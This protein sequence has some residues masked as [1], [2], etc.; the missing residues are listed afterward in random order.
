MEF[1]HRFFSDIEVAVDKGITRFFLYGENIDRDLFYNEILGVADLKDSLAFNLVLKKNIDNVFSFN[2]AGV[3]LNSKDF[4]SKKYVKQEALT[5]TEIDSRFLNANAEDK[6][7]DPF[8]NIR[9]TDK[10]NQKT[11]EVALEATKGVRQPDNILSNYLV[12]FTN[13][14]KSRKEPIAIII[15]DLDW[16]VELFKG[17]EHK[18][19]ILEEIDKWKNI[20]QVPHLTF[21][22]IRS[23]D[24]LKTY[25]NIDEKH[26]GI[27]YIGSPTVK[28]IEL[29]YSRNNLLFSE[30]TKRLKE[31]TLKVLAAHSKN[32]KNLLLHSIHL[33]ATVKHSLGD[34]FYD[35]KI[36]IKEFKERLNS[37]LEEVKWD[38]VFLNHEEKIEIERIF[39]TFREGNVE[40]KKT[41]PK[42]IILYGPPGTGK[43]HIARALSNMGGYF[44][45]PLKLADIKGEFVGQSGKN[46]QRIFREARISAPTLLFIDEVDTIFGR[47]GSGDQ[48]SYSIDII[49]Q[50]L[51]ETDGVDTAGQ[52]IFIVCTTNRLEMVDP[53]II[54][55]FKP[56]KVDLPDENNRKNLTLYFLKNGIDPEQN[57]N[58]LKE[59]IQ[60]SK[61]LSGRD[62]KTLSGHI[63]KELVSGINLLEAIRKTF[64]KLKENIVSIESSEVFAPKLYT[65]N[66]TYPLFTHIIGYN[67]VKQ[68]IKDL[69]QLMKEP[70]KFERFGIEKINGILLYGPPGN[71]KTQFAEAC[72]NEFGMDYV[73]I[74]SSNL[75]NSLVSGMIKQIEEA[76]EK[77]IILSNFNPVLLFFDEFDAI[78]SIEALDIRFR[79]ALLDSINRIRKMNH[80]I[81]MAATNFHDRLD[82]AVIRKG[83]FDKHIEFPNPKEENIIPLIQYFISDERY[84]SDTL[85]YEIIKKRIYKFKEKPSTSDVKTFC[86]E[87]KMDAVIKGRFNSDGKVILRTE[88]FK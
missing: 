57:K 41:L 16:I 63:K 3:V 24:E 74:V 72:A 1:K 6:E 76:V 67:E 37:T 59:I 17:R 9:E 20:S 36:V 42:G 85:D 19:K 83:R 2:R 25:Y 78:A 71:G 56:V 7:N 75:A 55:R 27:I 22:I 13:I 32:S 10:P 49:N 82:E 33:L 46:V 60:K 8:N 51:S 23:L 73:K 31:N 52:N 11:T 45:Y 58:E 64:S 53:A 44:F 69:I 35:D 50:F 80:I 39:Q 79:G 84:C 43:T 18:I 40:E 61:G 21:I 4:N 47:R 62:I 65:S 28:E 68:K 5:H 81:L 70:E 12:R 29:A 48:D 26:E 15:D 88:H 38:D 34:Q 77:T 30:N 54:S 66:N 86:E 87:A 14:L